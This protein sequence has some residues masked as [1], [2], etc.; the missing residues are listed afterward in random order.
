[1]NINSPIL[2]ELI[3]IRN[4]KKNKYNNF[5]I[6]LINYLNSDEVERDLKEVIDGGNSTFNL[7]LNHLQGMNNLGDLNIG[8]VNLGELN[9]V[10]LDL[11]HILIE[12]NINNLKNLIFLSLYFSKCP[13]L[14]N[15]LSFQEVIQ[16]FKTTEIIDINNQTKMFIEIENFNDKIKE[17]KCIIGEKEALREIQ[18]SIIQMLASSF[19]SANVDINNIFNYYQIIN[20]FRDVDFCL[21]IMS[22]SMIT[23]FNSKNH[24]FSDEMNL[25][26]VDSEYRFTIYLLYTK[27]IDV[28]NKI[29]E[30]EQKK[31][32]E[33][34]TIKDFIIIGNDYFHNKIKN[35]E[36]NI[37]ANSF[38]YLNMEKLPKFLDENRPKKSNKLSTFFYFLII[39][40]EEFYKNFENI[41]TMCFEYGI[42]FLVFL[43]ITS[44]TI[45]R[46][47]NNI[48]YY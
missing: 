33:A 43:Y 36:K 5:C 9:L 14:L 15:Y 38:N 1:M 22:I 11:N 8:G 19:K 48:I 35:I 26:L 28:E 23:N 34:L 40:L 24:N 17:N 27:Q 2:K 37:K 4:L 3:R 47:K 21:K 10:D 12:S 42:T 18:I 44:F 45:S 20:F 32:Y 31:I 46:K 6:K 25:C 29:T 16:I 7:I 30:E 39:R 13:Y 41:F